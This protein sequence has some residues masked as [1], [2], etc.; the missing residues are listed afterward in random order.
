MSE[1]KNY[2]NYKIDEPV[3]A[4]CADTGLVFN[5]HFAGI[6]DDGYPMAWEDGKTSW[7]T[8]NAVVCDDVSKPNGEI[9]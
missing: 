8:Q 9:K 1:V 7:S 2:D 3:K 6:A 5:W 4:V